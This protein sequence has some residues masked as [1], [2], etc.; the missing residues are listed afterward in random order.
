[1]LF[2]LAYHHVV[3]RLM[4]LVIAGAA[5]PVVIVTVILHHCTADGPLL[6]PTEGTHAITPIISSSA[7]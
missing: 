2:V 7:I 4:L 1:M 5:L 3:L 6:V